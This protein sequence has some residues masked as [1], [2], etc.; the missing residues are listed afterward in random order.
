MYHQSVLVKLN[1]ELIHLAVVHR[2]CCCHSCCSSQCASHRCCKQNQDLIKR[3]TVRQQADK[4]A[5]G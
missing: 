5:I 3:I 2:D 1:F 4:E